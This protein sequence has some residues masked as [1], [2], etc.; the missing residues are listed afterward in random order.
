MAAEKLPDFLARHP[1][2]IESAPYLADL[3]RLEFGA[4][5][6]QKES[7][8]LLETVTSQTIN[9][10]LELFPVFRSGLPEMLAGLPQSP[11]RQET[12]VGVYR[13]PGSER[14]KIA[15]LSAHD[16]LALKLVSEKIDSAAAAKEGGVTRGTIDDII[17]AAVDCGL[18]LVPPSKIVRESGFPR[19]IVVDP[20]P[21]MAP[22]F[23]LQWHITQ[24]CDLHCRHCYDRSD[25]RTLPLKE[26]ILILDDL[27]NFCRDHH[28]FG[29]VTFTGGNPL[30]YPHFNELYREA[31]ER[32]FIIGILGNP[33]PRRR[34]EELVAVQ[35]PAFYQVSL[36]G[37]R[38]HNDFMRGEGHF[39]RVMGFL[40]VLADL[41]VY[42]MVM[43]TLTRDNME[44]VLDLAVYLKGRVNQFTFNRLA[45]VGEG[46][47]LVS[48]EPSAYAEFLEH[49]LEASEAH[50]HMSLKDN[51]F[52]L[53]L[54]GKGV[55]LT[56]GCTDSGCGAAFNFVALLP[57][58]EV[59]AC[60]KFPS[61]IGNIHEQRLAEVYQSEAAKM[62]RAGSSACRDCEIRPVCGGCLA[63]AHGF[64][65]DI[66][67]DRDPYCFKS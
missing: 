37:L 65:K 51:L 52:N 58:G 48:A 13:Q 50:T 21:F 3:A 25:R 33:A 49:Y 47:D 23:T 61:P 66:Y 46:A 27:Y 17:L 53:L 11:Q 10:S 18:I 30:M 5:L 36:E 35:K 16:L 63:V 31:A 4:Y 26:A 54:H 56:G 55:P 57:D 64:G 62:Y 43:L 45:M 1:E 19:G 40:P 42:S 12:F 6:L 60:R 29:Q 22:T 20:E 9:P 41:G 8:P 67:Q 39:D 15:T 7:L 59:H 44:Q 32:G 28:V 38:D 2:L 34:I 14:I 24:T